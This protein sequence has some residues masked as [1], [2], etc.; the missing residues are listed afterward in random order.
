M[1]HVDKRFVAYHLL[2]AA[3]AGAVLF[4]ISLRAS[5]YERA[6]QRDFKLSEGI[7]RAERALGDLMETL[8]QTESGVRRYLLT[9]EDKWLGNPAAK[10]KALA[11]VEDYRAERAAG[12]GAPAVETLLRQEV[13]QKFD[14]WSRMVDLARAEGAEAALRFAADEPGPTSMSRIGDAVAE[15]RKNTE[16]L[17][18]KRHEETSRTLQ[19]LHRTS[20]EGMAAILALSG[21]AIFAIASRTRQLIRARHD[22]REANRQ[23][24]TRVRERTRELQRSNEEIQRYAHVVGHD[25]RAPLV[26]IMGFTREL[27]DAAE[28]LKAYVDSERAGAPFARMNEVYAAVD[29][30]APEA[31]RFIHSSLQRM[32]ALIAGILHLSRLGRAPLHPQRI[33]MSELLDDCLSQI[34]KQLVESGGEASVAAPLPDIV[35]D[36]NAVKQIFTNLLDNAVKYFAPGRAGK[37]V[38]SGEARGALAYFEIRDN[39]RG[40]AAQ[41]RERVFDLFRRAGPQDRPGEGVGLAHV[42]SLARRLGGE[43]HVE[44]DGVTGS[45]FRFSL[46]RNLDRIVQENSMA[47]N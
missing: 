46:A 39:G 18:R 3:A 6:V 5:E 9:P 29:E 22:L 41:D 10:A 26:N 1:K 43:I 30:E 21:L 25:L 19:N 27:E 8:L 4:W 37:I 14:H 33:D 35:S 42:R 23:L 11:D 28:V 45:V 34:R 24:E 7:G 44:S 20:W 38:I 36:A 47:E 12:D 16:L 15:A 32:D 31:L 2:L 17:R 40:V 13:E